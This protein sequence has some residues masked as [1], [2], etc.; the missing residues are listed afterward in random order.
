[1]ATEIITVFTSNDSEW[2]CIYNPGS[3][4]MSAEDLTKCMTI[5]KN[6]AKKLDKLLKVAQ[7]KIAGF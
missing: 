7:E 4:P 1:M 2:T 3:R 6:R 5:G